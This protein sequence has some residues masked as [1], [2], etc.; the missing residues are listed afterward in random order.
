MRRIRHVALLVVGMV[1]MWC[2]TALAALHLPIYN[3]GSNANINSCIR[4]VMQQD[5]PQFT[6]IA[7]D[8]HGM[9]FKAR[10]HA[11][12]LSV[13]SLIIFTYSP[14]IDTGGNV[15]L[16]LTMYTST[17]MGEHVNFNNDTVLQKIRA[18]NDGLYY[19]GI[20]FKGNKIKH[21][22][23]NSRGYS[24]G[25]RDGDEITYITV[26]GNEYHTKS[27]PLFLIRLTMWNKVTLK[28]KSGK[29]VTIEGEYNT[30]EEI[31]QQILS[32]K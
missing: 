5:F 8:E 11:L 29:V 13:D 14:R 9:T 23:T 17:E 7:Q 4:T 12:F 18:M 31:R 16:D 3:P 19:Y 10:S 32:I 1:C 28:T 2:S 26:C 24:A 20:T 15:Y 30:P 6:M 21:I 22:D 27:Y 25:L